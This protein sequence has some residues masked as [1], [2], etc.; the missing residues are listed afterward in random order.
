MSA[1]ELLQSAVCNQPAVPFQSSPDDLFRVLK[2]ILKERKITYQ[3]LAK[4]LS[5]S[6]STL[7]GI[8]HTKDISLHRLL[9]ICQ[10]LQLPLEELVQMAARQKENEFIF[11]PEQDEFFAGHPGHYYFFREIFFE[12]KNLLQM[13]KEFGLKQ[14]SIFRYLLDLEKI[15][16]LELDVFNKIKFHLSGRQKWDF[17]GKWMKKFLKKFLTDIVDLI[18]NNTSHY[19]S[20]YSSS[21][22]FFTTSKENYER[23][24]MEIQLVEKK[25]REI[26]HQDYMMNRNKD[27]VPVTWS[28]NIVEA[29]LYRLNTHI[30]NL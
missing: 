25:Y 29:D 11:T 18:H 26:A 13:E 15:G 21:V 9:E 4:D 23:F 17:R 16:I 6:V 2:T 20:A 22:G 10:A 8:F 12:K 19:S 7:K 24:K 27:Q 28:F 14:K 30:P 3:E 1:T 5:F